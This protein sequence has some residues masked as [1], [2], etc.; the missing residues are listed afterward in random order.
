MLLFALVQRSL[1][2]AYFGGRFE[3]AADPLALAVALLFAWHPLQTEAVEYVTQRTELLMAFCYL[4]TLYASLRYWQAESRMAHTAWLVIASLACL[5][6]MASKEVMVTAPVV[7]FLFERTF[8]SGTVRQTLKNSWRLYVGLAVGWL[9]LLALNLGG[10]RSASAGFHLDVPPYVWW[11]TQAKVFL[12][13]LRLVVWPWPLVIHYEIPYVST[14]ATAWPYMAAVAFAGLWTLWLVWRGTASGFL[15]CCVFLILS[16]TLV[17]PVVTEVAA[18][19]RL[20][21]PLAA[22]AALVVLGGYAAAQ[23]VTRRTAADRTPLVLTL[24]PVLAVAVVFALVSSRRLQA[25]AD[26]VILWQEAVTHQPNSAVIYNNLS[27]ELLGAGRIDEALETVRAG[28]KIA[29]D[30]PR[31]HNNLGVA[32]LKLGTRDGF[33]PGQLEEAISQFNEAARLGADSADGSI[34]LGFALLEDQR[35]D[36]AVKQFSRILAIEPYNAE[37]CMAWAASWPRAGSEPKRAITSR[38]PWSAIRTWPKHT[39]TWRCY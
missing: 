8:V 39:M 6:G 19:R 36:E 22:L 29:P 20:Y 5:A 17:V 12:M 2:L 31:L 14:F 28:L 30:Y 32:L 35:P 9:L 1:R 11:F 38:A 25:Y 37:R 34:N 4:A 21:L 26:P 33:R 15:L 10:P 13:Y 18:E 16:P 7:V 27:S 24:V 3:K 23:R